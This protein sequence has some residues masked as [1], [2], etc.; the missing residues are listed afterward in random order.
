MI[1]DAERL[2]LR[3]AVTIFDAHFFSF[4]RR[5]KWYDKT[6]FHVEDDSLRFMLYA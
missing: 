6:T 4:R 1:Q 2:T 5:M 3:T